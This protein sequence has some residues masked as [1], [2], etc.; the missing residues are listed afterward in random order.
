VT[1]SH[2]IR[3]TMNRS[4]SFAI[5]FAAFSLCLSDSDAR[6]ELPRAYMSWSAEAKEELLW[7]RIV[8]S[9]YP[10]L[11]DIEG[12]GWMGILESLK[13]LG[14]LGKSF[15]HVSDELP[16]G[17]KKLLH[18]NGS[19]VRV[20][21]VAVA[22]SSYTGLFQG[23]SGLARL[24]LA[25]DP[26]KIGYTPGMA[27]KFFVDGRPSVNV[28]V[29]SSLDGQGDDRNFFAREFTNALKKPRGIALKLVAAFF[30]LFADPLH[31]P[32]GQLARVDRYGVAVESPSSLAQLVL[33]PTRDAQIDPASTSDFRLE[34]AR[35]PEG[36]TLYEVW[37][38]DSSSSLVHVGKLVTR[39]RFVASEYG[40]YQLFFQHQR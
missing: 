4:S 40:D 17:R 35:I 13:T 33:A 24:S 37:A 18:P 9:E 20:E 8:S 21:L 12:A 16:H 30:S 29:M 25:G 31:V 26:K 28:H 3:C 34:L 2:I 27:L 36:S 38:Y 22:G 39:S 32:M 6:A 15:D 10:Q 19:V 14:T 7:N 5:A 11:R 1:G 23:A